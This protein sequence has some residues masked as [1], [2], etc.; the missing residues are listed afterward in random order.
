[1]REGERVYVTIRGGGGHSPPPF[2]DTSI[3]LHF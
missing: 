1:M 2:D 3:F